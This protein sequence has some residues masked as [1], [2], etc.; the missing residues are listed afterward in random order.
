MPPLHASINSAAS[1]ISSLLEKSILLRHP[2]SIGRWRFST[3]TF[4]SWQIVGKSKKRSMQNKWT[5]TKDDSSQHGLSRYT[6]LT[7][8]VLLGL[9]AVA[10]NPT[11]KATARQGMT[12]WHSAWDH[13]SLRC[14]ARR[15]QPDTGLGQ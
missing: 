5:Y 2:G 15:R 12:Y 10:S 14:T 8:E 11:K 13:S 1:S 3:H 7:A 9:F 4:S 6:G